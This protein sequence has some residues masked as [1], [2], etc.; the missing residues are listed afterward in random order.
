MIAV[1]LVTMSSFVF[2]LQYHGVVIVGLSSLMHVKLIPRLAAIIH[3][4]Y[5]VDNSTTEVQLD[6]NAELHMSK[7]TLYRNDEA[8]LEAHSCVRVSLLVEECGYIL[9]FSKLLTQIRTSLDK[10][11]GERTDIQVF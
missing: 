8:L 4:F 7:K 9:S 1:S 10:Y 11:L 2:T 3:S 6:A 5:R